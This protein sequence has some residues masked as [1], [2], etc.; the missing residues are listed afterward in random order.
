LGYDLATA[1][2][3]T[4]EDYMFNVMTQNMDHHIGRLIGT[5]SGGVAGVFDFDPI[6]GPQLR[7]TIIIFMGDNG[8]HADIAIDEPKTFV[9]EGSVHVP[10]IIA[11]GQAVMNEINAQ[12]VVPRFLDASRL[13]TESTLMVHAVDLYLTIARLADPAASVFPSNTDSKD[14]GRVLT[15]PLVVPVSRLMDPFPVAPVPP[16]LPIVRAYNFSQWYTATEM[17]ATIRDGSYKLNYN[18]KVLD[19]PPG[20]YTLYQ[21]TDGKIPGREDGTGVNPAIDLYNDAKSG[22]NPEA[23]DHLNAL[24]EELINNYRRNE[25]EAFPRPFEL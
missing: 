16:V 14:L 21:Y 7:N 17:R 4:S 22:A 3:P 24:L 5:V 18:Y 1:G 9:Y 19:G 2:D 12:A 13:D 10:M 8:S 20:R 25:T 6:P 23:R 15:T 11:D